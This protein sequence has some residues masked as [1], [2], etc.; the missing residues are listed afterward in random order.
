MRSRALRI[1]FAQTR[2]E[3]AP[4][5][6][7]ETYVRSHEGTTNS[8]TQEWLLIGGGFGKVDRSYRRCPG[9]SLGRVPGRS[10]AVLGGRWGLAIRGIL[11]LGSQGGQLAMGRLC[12]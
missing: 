5:K 12:G 10:P 11:R 9:C 8:H 1:L 6:R 3:T 7:R 4:R 2:G